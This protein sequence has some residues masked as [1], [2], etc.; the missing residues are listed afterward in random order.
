MSDFRI[1]LLPSI[2]IGRKN[3]ISVGPYLLA[4]QWKISHQN[5]SAVFLVNLKKKK[6]K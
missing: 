4:L 2:G 6:E 1:F 5:V 3:P